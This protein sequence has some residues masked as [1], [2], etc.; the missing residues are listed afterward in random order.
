MRLCI[1]TRFFSLETR[2]SAHANDTGTAES[3]ASAPRRRIPDLPPGDPDIGGSRMAAGWQ[4][5]FFVVKKAQDSA[6]IFVS[7]FAVR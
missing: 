5:A 1:C 4:H 6:Q 7:D 2:A 3:H